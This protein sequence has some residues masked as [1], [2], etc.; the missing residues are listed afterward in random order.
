MRSAALAL[1]ALTTVAGAASAQTPTQTPAQQLIEERSGQQVSQ[2]QIL[3]RLQTSGLSRSQV[4]NRLLGM[5]LDPALADSYFDQLEGRALGPLPAP[6]DSFVTAL[7]RMGLVDPRTPGVSPLG[8][9]DSQADSLSLLGALGPRP[10]SVST[11]GEL[12][13]FGKATFAR[14]TSQFRPLLT[15]PAPPDYALGPGDEVSLVLTGDVELAYALPVS[16]EGSI[17][18]PDVGQVIVNGLTLAQLEDRLFD[19]LGR[20]YS[21]IQRGPDA[22]TQ[23]QLSLGRLR[24]NEVFVVGEVEYPGAYEV[25]ALATPLGALYQAGGPTTEGSFRRIE[26]RR[27]GTVVAE[28]DLYEYLLAA[29]TGGDTRLE[30]G[31]IVFVPIAGARVYL[32]GAVPRNAV[33]EV[34]EGEGLRGVL[35]FAGGADPEADLERIRI[36]RILPPAKR[37]EQRERVLLDVDLVNVEVSKGVVSLLDGDRVQVPEIGEE[38]RNRVVLAGSVFRPGVFELSPDMTVWGLIRR[39]GGL[40]PEAFQPVAHVTRL[41]PVDSTFVLRR[42]SLETDA[43]G[44]PSDDLRLEDQDSVT[45][46]GRATLG[47]PRWVRIEGE[48]KEPGRVVLA[49]GM[50]VEDLILSA[51]GFTER[52]QG[53]SVEVAR[54]EPS[55]VRQSQVAQVFAVSLEG[56]IPWNV[57]GRTLATSPTSGALLDQAATNDADSGPEPAPLPSASN[58]PLM[59]GD[60]VIV[61]PLPG[62]VDEATVEVIGQVRFPGWYALLRREERL[63]SLVR[64]AG[65]FTEAAYVDGANL[66][67]DSTLVGIDLTDVMENPGSDG[68]VVLRPNDIL[69]VPFLDGTVL[70]RGAVASETRVIYDEGLDF[71]EYI[72]R[73][74]GTMAEADMGRAN[75]LYANGE[76]AV[77]KDFLI[78]FTDHPDVKPG[79]TITVPFAQEAPPTD[80]SQIVPQG[81]GI[82][83]SVVMIVVALSR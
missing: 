60:R 27:G 3:E 16:R 61:R 50:T 30:H 6:D 75:V 18:I 35:D 71:E 14:R 2:Q 12:P 83:G 23:F 44:A 52:A 58:V 67:R 81:L 38:R 15:G 78:F 29:D 1:I 56:T 37:S 34:A 43:G 68:D 57:L 33:F 4:R 28:V 74:G 17:V 31:D 63:S 49:D 47:T 46:F 45:V 25:S 21:G 70:V 13:V 19:R 73:S 62:Y 76:R 53:Q 41:S 7:V 40:R 66:M 9:M 24:L 80:W 72:E 54:L 55:L 10:D 82:L 8:P 5:G 48:V 77:V 26:V 39:G 65:G 69:E 79:S 32:E 11:D 22:S 64:R 51:G 20:V 36:D 59:E 42:V